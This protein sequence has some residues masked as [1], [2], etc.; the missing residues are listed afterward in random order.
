MKKLSKSVKQ[1][2]GVTQASA[3]NKSVKQF[4]KNQKLAGAHGSRTHQRRSVPLNGFEVREAHRDSTAP[5]DPE[6]AL[7]QQSNHGPACNL[8]R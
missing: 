1:T 2:S 7:L 3:I 6:P 8:N 5:T 4:V